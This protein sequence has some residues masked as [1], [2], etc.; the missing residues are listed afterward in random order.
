MHCKRNGCPWPAHAMG[1]CRSHHLTC[2]SREEREGR[3]M[4]EFLVPVPA[5]VK[6]LQSP[7]KPKR[8]GGPGRG[9]KGPMVAAADSF[10][11]R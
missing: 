11:N 10:G 3:I 1:Y 7:P 5:A 2:V 6:D 9:H 4:R 8:R